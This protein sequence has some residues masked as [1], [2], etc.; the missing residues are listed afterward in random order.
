M[1]DTHAALR[2][3]PL[4]RAHAMRHPDPAPVRAR[5]PTLPRPRNRLKERLLALLGL[6]PA[7]AKTRAPKGG[8]C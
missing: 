3:E 8:C 6:R 2:A 5:G 1:I 7:R 4:A